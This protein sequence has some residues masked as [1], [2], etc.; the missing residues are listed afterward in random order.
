MSDISIKIEESFLIDNKIKIVSKKAVLYRVAT[1]SLEKVTLEKHN[2][3]LLNSIVGMDITSI[4]SEDTKVGTV[5]QKMKSDIVPEVSKRINDIARDFVM[6]DK[7]ITE[8]LFD[9][10]TVI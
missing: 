6:D 7:V 8:I 3:I 1:V 4:I 10:V 9:G 2:V 5:T